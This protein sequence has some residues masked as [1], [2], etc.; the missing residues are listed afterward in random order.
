MNGGPE[1]R[2]KCRLVFPLPLAIPPVS[3]GGLAPLK[4]FF[5]PFTGAV[6]PFWRL[7]CRYEGLIGT[8]RN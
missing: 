6:L 2:G 4:V 1:N 7:L 8:G 5:S 3:I